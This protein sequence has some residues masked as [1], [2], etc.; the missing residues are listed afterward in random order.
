MHIIKFHKSISSPDKR[1]QGEWKHTKEH[2]MFFANKN[3]AQEFYDELLNHEG[4][5]Y[6]DESGDSFSF[7]KIT[8]STIYG[9][10]K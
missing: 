10:N 2:E 5:T 3:D 7:K 1:G 9:K 8:W 4:E 6:V